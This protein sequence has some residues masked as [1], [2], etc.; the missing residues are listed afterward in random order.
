[1]LINL[2]E[3]R[4]DTFVIVKP[5]DLPVRL[6]Y[7]NNPRIDDLHL[8]AISLWQVRRLVGL[9]MILLVNTPHSQ[10][11]V[12]MNLKNAKFIIY[13]IYLQYPTEILLHAV[14]WQDMAGILP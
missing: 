7:A 9:D 10:I 2:L 8:R 14:Y 4:N 6:H 1:M 11:L 12:I 5:R 13:N 3:C